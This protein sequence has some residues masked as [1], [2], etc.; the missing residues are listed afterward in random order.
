MP[1]HVASV[2]CVLAL[3]LLQTV[4]GFGASTHTPKAG[5]SLP[6]QRMH[7]ARIHTAGNGTLIAPSSQ[8]DSVPLSRGIG[9][10]QC[11]N[12]VIMTS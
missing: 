10:E 1:L 2:V 5:P 8:R 12:A 9:T 11:A 6:R 4:A 7:A 3:G